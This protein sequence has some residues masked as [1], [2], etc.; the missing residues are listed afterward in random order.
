M[1]HFTSHSAGFHPP[2]GPLFP[3]LGNRLLSLGGSG[4]GLVYTASPTMDGF[5][6]YVDHCICTEQYML[7]KADHP[8]A[9]QVSMFLCRHQF[10]LCAG[11]NIFGAVLCNQP[12]N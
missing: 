2:I 9:Q 12:R 8:E 4:W 11:T 7:S 6:G 3:Q 10:L 1:E 5:T